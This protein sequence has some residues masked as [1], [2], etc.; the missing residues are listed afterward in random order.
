[1]ETT[2]TAVKASL[3]RAKK[4]FEKDLP[5]QSV[6]AFWSNEDK[7]LLFEL[8]YQ[9]LQAEDPSILT[10]CISKIPSLAEVSKLTKQKRSIT[11]LNFY[12]MAA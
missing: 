12:C 6:D 2:E 5:F 4:R 8:L 11:P 10:D 7:E 1:M 9:S 3:F